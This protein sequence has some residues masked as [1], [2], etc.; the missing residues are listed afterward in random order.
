ML[1]EL[2]DAGTALKDFESP[3]R[4]YH[5]AGSRLYQG[6]QSFPSAEGSDELK[7]DVT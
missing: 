5:G 4:T 6:T 1:S 7:T 3:T 2:L